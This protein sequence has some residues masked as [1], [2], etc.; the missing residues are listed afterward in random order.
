[1]NDNI[2]AI[3]ET[4]YQEFKKHKIAM[5]EYYAEQV[6]TAIDAA[7]YRKQSDTVKEFAEKIYEWADDAEKRINEDCTARDVYDAIQEVKKVA[8][9][10]GGEEKK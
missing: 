4:I 8:A 1:M 3:A 9:S 5:T 6:A 2:K 7:G 10:F